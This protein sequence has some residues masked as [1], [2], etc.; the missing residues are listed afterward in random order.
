VPVACAGPN[1]SD[2]AVKGVR[3]KTRID[4]KIYVFKIAVRFAACL[5][6]FIFLEIIR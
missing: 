5:L 1:T 3:I 4:N 2:I 6:T